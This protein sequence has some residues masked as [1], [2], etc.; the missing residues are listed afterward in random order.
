MDQTGGARDC[1]P[2]LERKIPGGSV[3][4]SAHTGFGAWPSRIATKGAIAQPGTEFPLSQHQ[5]NDYRALGVPTGAPSSPSRKMPRRHRAPPE[6]TGAR[7]S[8]FP[9]TNRADEVTAAML[10]AT[11]GA[12]GPRGSVS[13]GRPRFPP[14]DVALLQTKPTMSSASSSLR[15]MLFSSARANVQTRSG[16]AFPSPSW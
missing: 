1:G 9:P 4:F 14:G 15:P 2:V 10:A 5:R 16:N 8:A 7:D 11:P 3:R 13:S 6:Q 12:G